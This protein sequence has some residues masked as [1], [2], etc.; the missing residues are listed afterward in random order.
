MCADLVAARRWGGLD[1]DA[2][3]LCVVAMHALY[4]D[5]GRDPVVQ[6]LPAGQPSDTAR[7]YYR[8]VQRTLCDLLVPW[9][10]HPD[11]TAGKHR[12]SLAHILARQGEVLPAAGS[13]IR[14][15]ASTGR[16]VGDELRM[17]ASL[18]HMRANRFLGLGQER[19]RACHEVWALALDA[20]RRRPG[21]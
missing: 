2:D 20:I 1:L 12:E 14:E 8:R 5:W 7:K 3:L 6:A 21:A 10:A 18:A 13:L 9:D 15:L 4:R 16:L 19:E 11:E 17:L